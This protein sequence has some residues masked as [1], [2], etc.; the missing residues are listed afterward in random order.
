MDSILGLCYSVRSMGVPVK[1]ISLTLTQS[2]VNRALS[3]NRLMPTVTLM[4]YMKW[5]I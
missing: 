3:L 4:L 2:L 5:L 1:T